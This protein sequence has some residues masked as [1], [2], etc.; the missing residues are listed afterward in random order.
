VARED[1]R[2]HV[3]FNWGGRW[4]LYLEPRF[5]LRSL[6]D[7]TYQAGSDG[8]YAIDATFGFR[9][10]KL[11][12][13]LRL[14]AA[15][16]YTFN[17]V[18]QNHMAKL[19]MGRDFGQLAFVDIFGAFQYNDNTLIQNGV[20]GSGNPITPYGSGTQILGEGGLMGGVRWRDFMAYGLVDYFYDAGIRA[21]MG[22]LRLE[23]RL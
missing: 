8:S 6:D 18:S 4:T 10:R 9:D 2:V 16:T 13:D 1:V 5:R 23:Y 22:V 3:D 15:Y 11:P 21:L 7:V 12:G 20:D 17:Y 14:H 19:E